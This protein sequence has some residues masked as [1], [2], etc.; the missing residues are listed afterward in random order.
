MMDDEEEEL[1]ALRTLLKAGPR[2]NRA[3]PTGLAPEAPA[4]AL[5]DDDHDK[6]AS[7]LMELLQTGEGLE[8]AETL[9]RKELATRE[10]DYGFGHENTLVAASR[11][12]LLLQAKNQMDESLRLHRRVVEGYEILE[13][14]GPTHTDT[15]SAMN[16]LAVLLKNLGEFDRALPLYERVLAGDEAVHGT[17]HPH[18]LD[19]IYNLAR[20]FDAVGQREKAVT[21]YRR[22]LAGCVAHYGKAHAETMNSAVNLGNVLA[23][24]GDEAAADELGKE[25][26]LVEAGSTAAAVE[27][28]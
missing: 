22:E 1:R 26:G 14:H 4:P 18:T 11:L 6:K 24:M 10:V 3:R 12:A 17:G 25:F 19:S 7:K 20:L 28:S 23:T 9:M 8:E 15:L 27:A 5:S 16:N 21:L 2:T 13:T